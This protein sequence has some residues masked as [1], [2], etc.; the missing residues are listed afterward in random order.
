MPKSSNLE[1]KVALAG[2]PET[3]VPLTVVWPRI[4]GR[5]VVDFDPGDDVVERKLVIKPG[6][7][8]AEGARRGN[9]KPPLWCSGLCWRQGE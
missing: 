4:A 9:A 2:V 7:E 1:P 6:L 3:S 5:A 8:A